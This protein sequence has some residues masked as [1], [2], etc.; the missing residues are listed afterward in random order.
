MCKKALFLFVLVFLFFL[1]VKLSSREYIIT[2]AELQQLEMLYQ[3]SLENRR[4][5][6]S[7]LKE[8]RPLL[9]RQQKII[10][11]LQTES[12]QLSKNL[13]AER[14]TISDLTNSVSALETDIATERDKAAKIQQKLNDEKLTHQKT[15][16]QRNILFFTLIFILLAACGTV[17]VKVLIRVYKPF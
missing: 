7:E 5:A 17:A 11:T 14:Q 16:N 12:I 4:K 10:Q 2:E 9:G 15:K 3:S 13:Q 1:G 8:L 6:E